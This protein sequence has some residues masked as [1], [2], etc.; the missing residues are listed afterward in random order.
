MVVPYEEKIIP[1]DKEVI[2]KI[3]NKRNINK[4][5]KKN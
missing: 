5:I 4:E 2:E 3:L 1:S